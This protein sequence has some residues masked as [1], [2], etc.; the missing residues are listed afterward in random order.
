[1]EH[2]RGVV[3]GVG[4]P[5]DWQGMWFEVVPGVSLE[6]I[7]RMGKPAMNRTVLLD[8]FTNRI[9]RTQV[10]MGAIFD[11][12]FSQCDRNPQNMFMDDQGN[13]AYID[14][15]QAH[16]T[17]WRDCGIDSMLIPTT[18]KY[19]INRLGYFYVMK[20]PPEDPPK[21]R[22]TGSANPMILLDYRCHVD[23]GKIGKN[24]WPK[25][26]QCLKKLSG[27]TP[28]EVLQTY[29]Y[30]EKEMAAAVNQRAKDLLAGGFEWTVLNGMPRNPGPTRYKVTQPCCKFTYTPEEGYQCATKMDPDQELPQGDPYGG[31]KWGGTGKDTGSFDGA[32]LQQSF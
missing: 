28:D 31:G 18:Q 10:K 9:N 3:P 24:Y 14:N 4:Y 12:L 23:G 21:D 6:N 17:A 22:D 29:G 20:Y 26:T 2:V 16:A 13:I 27:M 8:L 1:M 30:P 11:T 25:L 15:D 5:I 19:E 7:A 32:A